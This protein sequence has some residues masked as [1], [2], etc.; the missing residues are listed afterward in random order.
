MF[1]F[2]L[3]RL[4]TWCWLG[5]PKS[6]K[7]Y[8]RNYL[9][10]FPQ[11]TGSSIYFCPHLIF[12]K[13][14]TPF[15]RYSITNYT[16]IESPNIEPLESGMKLGVVPSWGWPRPPDWNSN[17]STKTHLEPLS[18]GLVPVSKLISFITIQGF[19]LK[20]I[21]SSYVN[22]LLYGDMIRWQLSNCNLF[23]RKNANV[24]K[25]FFLS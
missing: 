5:G 16:S 13:F 6:S 19:L 15:Q 14:S 3:L 4:S 25:W 24:W 9:L 2:N 18:A 11:T 22:F 1:S 21:S 8:L 7:I 17:N 23:Y 10:N 20:Y 12:L